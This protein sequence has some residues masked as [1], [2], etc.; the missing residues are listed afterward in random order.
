VGRRPPGLRRI[1]LFVDVGLFADEILRPADRFRQLL[2]EG[3][4]AEAIIRVVPDPPAG[5]DELRE[6]FPELVDRRPRL[7]DVPDQEAD[8][9]PITVT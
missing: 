7:V 8:D 2:S 4:D 1:E 6:R 5:L 9:Q 3:Q